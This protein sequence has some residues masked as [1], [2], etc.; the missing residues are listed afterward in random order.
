MGIGGWRRL[1]PGVHV[2]LVGLAQAVVPV[3]IGRLALVILLHAQ[4]LATLRSGE[5]GPVQ[6]RVTEHGGVDGPVDIG[7]VERSVRWD[8]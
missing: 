6:R 8:E 2:A 5:V 3:G 1:R 7:V 4:Q